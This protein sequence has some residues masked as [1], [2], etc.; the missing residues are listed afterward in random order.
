MQLKEKHFIDSLILRKNYCRIVAKQLTDTFAT[1]VKKLEKVKGDGVLPQYKLCIAA[2]DN[3]LEY[4][5]L[6]ISSDESY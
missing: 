6:P 4:A 2:L 1:E 3:Y 5:K